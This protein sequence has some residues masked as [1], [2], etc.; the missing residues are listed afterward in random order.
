MGQ[1]YRILNKITGKSYIGQTTGLAINRFKDHARN[2]KNTYIGNI[3]N[4]YGKHNFKLYILEDNVP[5]SKL[6]IREQYYIEKYNT[7]NNGY[8]QTLG[9]AGIKGYNHTQETKNKISVASNNMFA[10][11]KFDVKKRNHKIS[12]A[13]TGRNKTV[14]HC[15]KLSDIA[16]MR[17]GDKNPFFGQH[18]TPKTKMAISKANSKSVFVY[19]TNFTFVNMFKNGKD[20]AKWLKNEV[21]LTGIKL[22][23]I[24]RGINRACNKGNLYKDYYFLYYKV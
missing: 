20:A 15:K 6:N 1:I 11:P 21:D 8:N 24:Y 2:N 16:K 7:F 14:E 17:T 12:E 4:K 13:L 18:H 3:I 9:G 19:D 10:N 23:S 5:K 22:E